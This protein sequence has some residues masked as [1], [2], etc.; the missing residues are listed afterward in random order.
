MA[1]EILMA[2][3]YGQQPLGSALKVFDEPH[4]LKIVIT[5]QLPLRSRAVRM[6][7]TR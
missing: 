4:G 6:G 2:L 1:D 5:I 7:L 3:P